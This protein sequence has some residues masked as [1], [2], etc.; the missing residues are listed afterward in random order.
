MKIVCVGGGP[1]G[2]YLAILMKK[3]D[4]AHRITVVER[5]QPS[6]TFGFGVVF[7]DQTLSY[8]R[9]ADADSHAQ[10]TRQFAHWDDIAIHYR[11]ELVTSTGHGFCGL[12]RQALLA[13]LQQR[14]QELGVEL[15]FEQELHGSDLDRYKDADLLLGTDGL[16][17]TV[18]THYEQEFGPQIDLRPNRFVWLGTTFPFK[19]FTFYFKQNAHGL[20]RVHAY[21]YAKDAPAGEPQSTFILECTDETFQR[22]GLSA[23]DEAGT[24][25][26][27]EQLFRDELA[28]HRLLNNRSIWRRFPTVRCHRWHYRNIALLGD[29]VHTAHFSIGSGTKLALEDAIALHDAL[30]QHPDI[31]TALAAYEA[32]RRPVVESL[33]RAAQTSLEW[34]ENTER[35]TGLPPLQFAFSLLTRSLRLT[36]ENLRLRDPA[37]IQRVD[38]QC[39]QAAVAQ[40]GAAAPQ[41]NPATDRAPPCPMT[42]PAVR[43]KAPPP[44]FT[45]FRLRELTLANRVVVSPMCQYSAEDGDIAEWHLV[46]LGSRAVGGAGL[47][48][49]EMTDVSREGRITPGCAGLYAPEHATSWARVT[50][51]VHRYSEAKVG[52]QLGHAGR[53]GAT[54]ILWEGEDVPLPASE[55]WPLLAASPLAWAPGSQLPRP[56]ERADMDAV[57]ADFVRATELAIEAGFDLIEVHMAHGYL[58]AGFLSPLTNQR[59]DEY[60]GSLE[61]R[62]R[63]PLEVLRAVRAVWPPERPLSVRISATDWAPGGT[64][65]GESVATARLLKAAGADIVAVSTGQTIPGARPMYGRLFQTPFAEQIRLEAAIPTIAVGMISSYTDVNSI[66][67]AGRADLVALARAHLYDPYWT[68][69]A[70]AEQEYELAWPQQYRSVARFRPRLK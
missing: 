26:Y 25:A 64:A 44:M 10:I 36:H 51:F 47:V 39:A 38:E 4:P 30:R 67:T 37:L 48:I 17:S 7:S 12:S 49:A 34:F 33:Q 24:L 65:A 19:A 50:T 69:H 32:A 52:I 11:G 31:A 20:W 2:L 28:G 8:L 3:A 43:A 41:A 58:L 21:R 27:C 29:A 40:L 68:R 66:I 46:H 1:A 15:R 53:K 55:A 70:A 23:T 45:K 42:T 5:N 6:D 35:Y 63:F 56:M 16:N 13:I 57:I 14:G 9:E 54:R 22:S 61:N 59:R 60:G 18:R 62:A